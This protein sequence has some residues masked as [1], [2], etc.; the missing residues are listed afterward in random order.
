M[1]EFLDDVHHEQRGEKIVTTTNVQENFDYVK[2]ESGTNT[3]NVMP[4]DV[5]EE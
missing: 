4:D 2:Q 1:Q 5:D 3:R